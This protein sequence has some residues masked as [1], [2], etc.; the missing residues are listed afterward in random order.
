[1][2]NLPIV[3]RSAAL[4]E[5]PTGVAHSQYFIVELQGGLQTQLPSLAGQEVGRLIV[6]P[7]LKS[8]SA[9]QFIIGQHQLHGRVERLKRPLAYM[10]PVRA[11]ESAVAHYAV[12][13]VIRY[14]V[15]FKDRPFL[16]LKPTNAAPATI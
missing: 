10:E 8:G 12:N 16:I 2:V 9:A 4:P 7:D 13:Q 15:L 14:R 1:M 3:I 11:T 5:G 6:D